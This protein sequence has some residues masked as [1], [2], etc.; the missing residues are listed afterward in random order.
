MKF[1]LFLK[2]NDGFGIIFWVFLCRV[3]FMLSMA[4]TIVF[5]TEAMIWFQI[6]LDKLHV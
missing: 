2:A 1:Q 4:G 6:L 5:Y 3:F